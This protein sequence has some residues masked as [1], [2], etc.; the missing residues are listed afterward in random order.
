MRSSA[1]RLEKP[2]AFSNM[3]EMCQ[4]QRNKIRQ[5]SNAGDTAVP[6]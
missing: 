2:L 1:E 5:K 6:H 4:L 3:V